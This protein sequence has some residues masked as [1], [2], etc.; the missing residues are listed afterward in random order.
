MAGDYPP[1]HTDDFLEFAR[2]LPTPHLFNAIAAAKP[3]TQPHGYRHTQN[4]VRHFDRLP[5]FL[6]GFL[7]CGDAVYTLNPVY[8]QGMTAALLGCR[9][10]DHCLQKFA[11]AGTLNGLARAFQMEL[12][13]MVVD[14]WRMAVHGDRR[15]P[16]TTITNNTL[17]KIR[18]VPASLYSASAA[19]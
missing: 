12:S 10:L 2:S 4:R 9:A 19:T 13:Q 8:S 6:E 18:R 14:P 11:Q 1:T 17:P 16:A 5:R 3:L 15:W 7:V